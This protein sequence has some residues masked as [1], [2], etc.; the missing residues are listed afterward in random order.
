[1]SVDFRLGFSLQGFWILYI[2]LLEFVTKDVLECVVNPTYLIGCCDCILI[3]LVLKTI[4]LVFNTSHKI[5]CCKYCYWLGSYNLWWVKL[6]SRVAV[7]C[8]YYITCLF[9][10]RETSTYNKLL[11]WYLFIYF[12]FVSYTLFLTFT[13]CDFWVSIKHGFLKVSPF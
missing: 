6:Q 12:Y 3:N 1:M 11:P 8:R 7:H 9:F 4:V 13:L 10:L 2:I 5:G